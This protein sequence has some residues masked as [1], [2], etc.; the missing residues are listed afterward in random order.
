[1]RVQRGDDAL[2]GRPVR[3]AATS[4]ASWSTPSSNTSASFVAKCLKRVAVDASAASAISRTPTWSKRRSWKSA[5]AASAMVGRVAAFFRSR[6]P[7]GSITRHVEIGFADA[8][9]P[10]ARYVVAAGNSPPCCGKAPLPPCLT[11]T[12]DERLPV[13]AAVLGLTDRL[14][15]H[16]PDST[17]DAADGQEMRQLGSP[18]AMA[19]CPPCSTWPVRSRAT[20]HRT[21]PATS[22]T[23]ARCACSTCSAERLDR[24]RVRHPTRPRPRRPRLPHC[25][26]R[27]RRGRRRRRR[28]PRPSRLL[29]PPRRAGARASRRPCR[30]PL[31]RPVRPHHLPRRRPSAP[32]RRAAVHGSARS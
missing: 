25:E 4:C 2:A 24:L 28:R 21:R 1:M 17:P 20:A 30:D 16:R 26:H 9:T 29:A 12:R 11:P 5:S 14:T 6:R 22:P 31:H 23:G 18:T 3:T 19:P 27:R 7:T 32:C 10:T 13:A 15:D 8:S